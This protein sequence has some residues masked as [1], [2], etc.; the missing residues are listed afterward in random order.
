MRLG[1]VIMRC[2]DR[3]TLRSGL[4][5]SGTIHEFDNGHALLIGDAQ[6]GV[7][8]GDAMALFGAAV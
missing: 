4:D 3:N 5:L 8:C 7:L 6:M 2:L 1:A